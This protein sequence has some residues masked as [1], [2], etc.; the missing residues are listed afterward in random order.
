[1]SA[2]KF[3]EYAAEHFDWPKTAKSGRERQTFEQMARAW[4]EATAL[5]GEDRAQALQPR[6][7]A[8]HGSPAAH[9]TVQ[10]G[11]HLF[12]AGPT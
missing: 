6:E 9:D 8:A 7:P 5:W 2:A 12:R 3:L 10:L 11:G 4:L 1:M